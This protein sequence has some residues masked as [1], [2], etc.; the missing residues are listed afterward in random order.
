VPARTKVA[1]VALAALVPLA[2]KVTPAG[3]TADQE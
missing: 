2:E 3:P 1:T